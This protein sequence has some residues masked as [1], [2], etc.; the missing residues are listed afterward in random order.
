MGKKINIDD[1]APLDV[2]KK[3]TPLQILD[4]IDLHIKQQGNKNESD[5]TETDRLDIANN[6]GTYEEQWREAV[7]SLHTYG[8]WY[9][10]ACQNL[11]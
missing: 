8:Y 9:G 4:V 6:Y 7:D 3:M 11:D 1:Y 5:W 10:G 2:L